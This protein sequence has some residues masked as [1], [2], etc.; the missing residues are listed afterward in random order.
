MM[1]VAIPGTGGRF[2]RSCSLAAAGLLAVAVVGCAAGSALRPL[3]PSHPASPAAAEA[4]TPEPAAMLR[5]SLPSG[6]GEPSEPPAHLGHTIHGGRRAGSATKISPRA[7]EYTCPMHHDVRQ[8]G[9]GRCPKCGM[10]L[11]RTEADDAGAEGRQ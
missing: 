1:G 10:T 7:A 3:D 2:A 8:A 9:P 4:T 6:E 11:V 5:D